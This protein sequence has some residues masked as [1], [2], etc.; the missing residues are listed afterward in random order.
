MR[1]L[2]SVPEKGFLIVWEWEWISHSEDEDDND[3]DYGGD[4]SQN[5][6]SSNEEPPPQSCVDFKCIGVTRDPVYQTILGDVRDKMQSGDTV[7]VK[8]F[9]EP[10]N[11]YD[12]SAIAF[13]C[14]HDSEWKTIGY[15]VS[16]ICKDVQAAIDNCVVLSVDFAWVKYKV[17]R[18]RPG[19]YAAVRITRTG[20]WSQSVREARSTFS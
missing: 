17:L 6:Q 16:E 15:V 10:E 3:R 14:F 5:S 11:L 1:H 8:L 13:K 18:K 9:P 12:A 4:D 2:R 7:P 20:E 19:F